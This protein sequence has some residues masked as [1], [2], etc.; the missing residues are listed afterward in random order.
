[1]HDLATHDIDLL[2][3]LLDCDVQR[4][5]AE[6]QTEIRTEHEDAVTA[7]LRFSNG[8]VAT[9]EA[10]WISPEKQRQLTLLGERGRATLDYLS[11]TLTLCQHEEAEGRAQSIPLQDAA[12]E[13]LRAELQAFVRA[14]RRLEPPAITA[15]DG[16][17]AVRIADA[18]VESGRTGQAVRLV[19]AR[20]AK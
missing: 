7:V 6:T 2:L 15:T 9:L 18:I 14:A 3:H 19:E 16:I 12:A 5:H 4:V 20:A 8:T 17:A 11:R 13:P 10:N 1:M